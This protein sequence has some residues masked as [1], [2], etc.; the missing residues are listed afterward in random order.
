[1]NSVF[2]SIG[3]V[4]R[5]VRVSCESPGLFRPPDSL[6]SLVTADVDT[7]GFD[8]RRAIEIPF[9]DRRSVYRACGKRRRVGLQMKVL[10]DVYKMRI[11]KFGVTVTAR[12]LNILVESSNGAGSFHPG[13][14]L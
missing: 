14:P 3:R 10:G 7:S 12:G 1:M 11:L 4:P 9:S 6:F 2:K 8:A 13:A 5:P